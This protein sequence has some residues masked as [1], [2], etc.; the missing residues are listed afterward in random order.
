MDEFGETGE[1][2]ITVLVDNRADLLVKSTRSVRRFTS[3][4]LL[5]EHG[6]AALVE[7]RQAGLCVL[8]DAGMGEDT[9]LE[10]MRRMKLDPRRIDVIALSHGHRDHTGGLARLLDALDLRPRARQW[11][12][13]AAP[14]DLCAYAEGRAIPIIAHPA[15]LRERWWVSRDGSMRGPDAP[16]RARWEAAGGR[17]VLSEGPFRLAPGCWTTGFVPRVSFERTQPLPGLRQ[18]VGDALLPDGLE[19]DQALLL[20]IAGKGLVIL[21]GCAH[22]G[23][24]NT[25]R[26][27]RQIAGVERV[28]ALLGGFHLAAAREPE[29][30]AT[31]AEIE[32]LE[33][34]LVSPT[35]CTG[36]AAIRRFAERM[37]G[38][39]V[40]SV[41]GT[42]FVV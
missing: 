2:A 34:V 28:Y 20:N 3:E 39:F 24:V 30:E 9:L 14:E 16:P 29:L 4:P 10:N 8:W 41:V 1:V 38:A 33:P 25:V 11:R 17:L 42:R 15:A 18:R 6:F 31:L 35:H 13:G 40:E 7:L 12:K 36:F 5:A 21:A 37:P 19:D 26:Y 22:A 32:R 27:A 23:I